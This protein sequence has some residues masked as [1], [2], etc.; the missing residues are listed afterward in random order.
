MP[1][2]SAADRERVTITKPLVIGF[3]SILGVAAGVGF[4]VGTGA[5]PWLPDA[6]AH[7]RISAAAMVAQPDPVTAEQV[8]NLS[9]QLS[10][11]AAA[12]DENIRQTRELN[13]R[14]SRLEGAFDER[15]R[16]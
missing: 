16:K 5:K 12:L 1:Q 10:A 3:L 8:R 6:E 14:L 9:A 2:T 11:T 13:G 15:S 7:P 4:T